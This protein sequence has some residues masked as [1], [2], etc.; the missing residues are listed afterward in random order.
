MATPAPSAR[1]GTRGITVIACLATLAAFE[2]ILRASFASA[3]GEVAAAYAYELP[4]LY[5]GALW[6]RANGPLSVPWFTP[7]FCGGL[8]AYANPQDGYFS[9]TQALD[10]AIGPVAAIQATT[11]VFAGLGFLGFYRLVRDVFSGGWG[12]AV[13]AAG[14]FALNGFV[15]WRVV[16]GEL[17]V[18]TFMLTPLVAWGTLVPMPEAKR[19]ALLARDTC[20]AGAAIGYTIHAGAID[21]LPL[22][23]LSVVAIALVHGA[24]TSATREAAGEMFARFLG[25]L[26]VG[27]ALAA[28][29]LAAMVAFLAHAAR[30]PAQV[31]GVRAAR[32]LFELVVIPLVA[33]P[34]MAHLDGA[35][36]NARG[37]WNP[38]ELELGVGP[39]PLALLGVGA[40]VGPIALAIRAVRGLPPGGAA[41]AGRSLAWGLALA[42]LLAVPLYLN[43]YDASLARVV[44]M[45]PLVRY[46]REL[47]RLLSV[48]VP[49]VV[50][51]SAI[52][53]DRLIDRRAQ[54]VVAIAA[55][56]LLLLGDR[57]RDTERE[58][59][60]A[61]GYSPAPIELAHQQL[62]ENH[63]VPPIQAIAPLELNR[64]PAFPLGQTAAGVSPYP[65]YEPMF[66]HLL[67]HFPKNDLHAGPVTDVTERE[68]NLLDAACFLFPGENGCVPGD[69][70]SAEEKDRFQRFRA[71]GPLAFVKPW[72]QRLAD[73]TSFVAVAT[74]LFVLLAW[75]LS[76]KK[77][78]AYLD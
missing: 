69:R 10:L 6:F 65:C 55:V 66:G 9:L 60:D 71:H 18:H 67:E 8:P 31:P 78:R 76:E 28:G 13:F 62:R 14:V 59:E 17:A 36:V 5:D 15:L 51:A 1:I 41:R 49:V 7:S 26:A 27:F 44:T 43:V 54:W 63:F 42:L 16:A 25:C 35:I 74:V 77:P 37:P 53:V 23:V 70:I 75:G 19:G 11:V 20:V 33:H 45:L 58:L 56:A 61:G 4:H 21:T 3:T 72:W 32:D 30:E 39:V 12:A 68:L 47:F 2:W 50:L 48:F 40:L 38:A 57:S 73:A 46:E 22:I 29:K 24:V 52:V 64:V 34:R